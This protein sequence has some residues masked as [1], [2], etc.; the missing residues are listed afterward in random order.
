MGIGMEKWEE[1][2]RNGNGNGDGDE[3]RRWCKEGKRE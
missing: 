1:G 3:K 2:N